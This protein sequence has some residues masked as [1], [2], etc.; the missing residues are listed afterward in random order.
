MNP[1]MQTLVIALAL[2]V[3]VAGG[4]A[5]TVAV[6]R[7][8]KTPENREPQT[9]RDPAG[10]TAPMLDAGSGS[11]PQPL[12]R[13]GLWVGILERFFVTGV[14]IAGVPALIAV[15]IA[16]KGLGRYPELREQQ[17]ASERFIVGTLASLT[18]AVG[19]GVGALAILGWDI[20]SLSPLPR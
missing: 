8:A 17:G 14:I 1:A 20:G 10:R 7:L 15:V 12:L 3:S 13:G 5:V 16:I 19:C 2:V 4:W 18:I 9:V 6:L 11:E